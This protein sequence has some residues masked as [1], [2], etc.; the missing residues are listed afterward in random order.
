MATGGASQITDSHMVGL[1]ASDC[2]SR[3]SKQA[4]DDDKVSVAIVVQS[5]R[6]EFGLFG[7]ASIRTTKW[8]ICI[9][10][11]TN[12]SFELKGQRAFL[13]GCTHRSKALLFMFTRS[14]VWF[15]WLQSMLP[16]LSRSGRRNKKIVIFFKTSRNWSGYRQTWFPDFVNKTS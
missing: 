5:R 13:R 3:V 4:N 12:D 10:N 7:S 2:I 15:W 14:V 8:I 9:Y 1:I 6:T 16:K 11:Q